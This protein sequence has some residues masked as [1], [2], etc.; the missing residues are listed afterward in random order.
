MSQDI[1]HEGWKDGD[2]AQCGPNCPAPPP[3]VG[4][5]EPEQPA[6]LVFW[7][8]PKKKHLFKHKTIGYIFPGEAFYGTAMS[9]LMIATVWTLLQRPVPTD[10]LVELSRINSVMGDKS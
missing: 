3:H 10:V 1:Q 4:D 6:M 7:S 9:H 8:E 2:S 5:T